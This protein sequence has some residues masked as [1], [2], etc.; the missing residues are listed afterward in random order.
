[1]DGETSSVFLNL[2]G[3]ALDDS[4]DNFSLVAFVSDSL[5][6]VRAS[7]GVFHDLL[8][9]L[10]SGEL[11][12]SWT[13]SEYSVMGFHAL[14]SSSVPSLRAGFDTDLVLVVG[15]SSW[16]LVGNFPLLFPFGVALVPH[17]FEFLS[18]DNLGARSV[19][20]SFS[21]SGAPFRVVLDDVFNGPTVPS[22]VRSDPD[23]VPSEV[24]S[25]TTDAP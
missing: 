4:L 13:A 12:S 11:E 5:V 23:F 14:E 3:L 7:D 20:S 15:V 9:A 8:D 17:V 25:L 16:A 6:S 22:R 19:S 18:G 1:V 24:S 2:S 21:G 10:L